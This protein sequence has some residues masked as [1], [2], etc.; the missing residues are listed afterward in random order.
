M[1][2]QRHLSSYLRTVD[3][4]FI[5]SGMNSSYLRTVDLL[6]I[7]SGMNSS[8]ISVRFFFNFNSFNFII[9]CRYLVETTVRIIK[10][11]EAGFYLLSHVGFSVVY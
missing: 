4:L 9:K 3:L 6:F 5:G 8:L 7:G 2:V 11:I 1:R 10:K